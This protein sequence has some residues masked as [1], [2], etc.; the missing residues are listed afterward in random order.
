MEEL[1]AEH[2]ANQAQLAAEQAEGE[3][4]KK[5]IRLIGKVIEAKDNGISH[6]AL[7]KAEMFLSELAAGCLDGTEVEELDEVTEGHTKLIDIKSA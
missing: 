4:I 7:D 5:V 2:L 3:Y 1:Y 6:E